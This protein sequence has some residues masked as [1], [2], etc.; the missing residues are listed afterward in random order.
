MKPSRKDR[1]R[2]YLNPMHV[3]C[4]LMDAVDGFCAFYEKIYRL[5]L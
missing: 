2:H 5:M 1:V 3:K 4:R